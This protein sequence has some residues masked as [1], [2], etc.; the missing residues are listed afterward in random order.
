LRGDARFGMDKAS[1]LFEA[2][3]FIIAKTKLRKALLQRR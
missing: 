3:T 2:A 1:R